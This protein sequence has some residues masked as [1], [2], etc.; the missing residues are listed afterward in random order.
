MFAVSAIGV[1]LAMVAASQLG[2]HARMTIAVG[3]FVGVLL[4]G[5]GLMFAQRLVNVAASRRNGDLGYLDFRM[6]DGLA[7]GAIVVASLATGFVIALQ[8]ARQ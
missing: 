4:I 2:T 5:T 3:G 8:V 1:I 6:I 7:F